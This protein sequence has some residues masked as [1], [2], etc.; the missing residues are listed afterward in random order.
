MNVQKVIIDFV[1]RDLVQALA[2]SDEWQQI[3]LDHLQQ[4]QDIGFEGQ[5]SNAAT[6]PAAA[7]RGDARQGAQGAAGLG[8]AVD[9]VA[10]LA[11]IGRL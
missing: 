10:L 9:M 3:R 2:L 4:D 6:Q 11:V 8:R 1:D 5:L 7:D